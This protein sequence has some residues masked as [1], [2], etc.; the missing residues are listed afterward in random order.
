MKQSIKDMENFPKLQKIKLETITFLPSR[1]RLLTSRLERR[2]SKKRMK[3]ETF[4]TTFFFTRERT[5]FQDLEASMETFN[6]V[7]E[8]NTL[9][10]ACQTSEQSKQELEEAPHVCGGARQARNK[11]IKNAR[12]QERGE[13]ALLSQM[14][15]NYGA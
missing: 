14:G 1:T 15:H 12:F 10:K 2:A 6:G 3:M 4:N 8:E 5:F 13:L 9:G 7:G 11:H